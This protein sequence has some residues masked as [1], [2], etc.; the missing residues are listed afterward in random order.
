MFFLKR[1]PF[2]IQPSRFCMAAANCLRRPKYNSEWRCF[3]PS[4]SPHTI[5]IS[6]TRYCVERH[7]IQNHF[8]AVLSINQFSFCFT[9][10]KVLV[11]ANLWNDPSTFV[12]LAQYLSRNVRL[13]ICFFFCSF[14]WWETLLVL[15]LT[16]RDKILHFKI[17]VDQKLVGASISA[18]DAFNWR[19]PKYEWIMK[20]NSGQK[21][22]HAFR[23]IEFDADMKY[24]VILLLSLSLFT[25]L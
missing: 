16:G 24:N 6:F 19:W 20:R 13:F 25:F 22:S 17:E 14:S 18:G 10:N 9:F 7:I 2:Y 11:T 21:C 23:F 5:K 3:D 12:W 8:C 4:W 1:I 15:Q